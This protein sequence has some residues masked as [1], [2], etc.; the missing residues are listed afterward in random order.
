[1][2]FLTV[3][4]LRTKI[5]MVRENLKEEK[6]MVLTANGHP[7]AILSFVSSDGVEEELTAI[8]RA[9]A[10][11]AL[12]HLRA[13]AKTAGIDRWG[14]DDVGRVVAKSRRERRAGR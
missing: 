11:M 13:A 3:R 10:R 12:D 2:K 7:F 1:M 9:R 14:P 5:G 8:R 6:E 4:D